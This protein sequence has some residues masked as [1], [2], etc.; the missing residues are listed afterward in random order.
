M[1]SIIYSVLIEIY[2][3]LHLWT[4]TENS[5]AGSKS[6]DYP[7]FCLPLLIPL[8]LTPFSLILIIS[9]ISVFWSS[10][11]SSFPSTGPTL[12]SLSKTIQN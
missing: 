3:A 2:V 4:K 1:L 7:S 12:F 11:V 10:T 8:S 5:S 6:G 9:L